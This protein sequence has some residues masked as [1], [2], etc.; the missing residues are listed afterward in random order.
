MGDTLPYHTE[1]V[2]QEVTIQDKIAKV[3]RDQASV[4]SE[5][6]TMYG[7]NFSYTVQSMP[8]NLLWV[9]LSE[10]AKTVES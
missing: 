1:S 10:A 9:C 5:I 8:I 6:C 3:D 4:E 2:I 7:T